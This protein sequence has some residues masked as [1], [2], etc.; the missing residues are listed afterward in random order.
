[1]GPLHKEYNLLPYL[2]SGV[3]YNDVIYFI[4]LLQSGFNYSCW[5]PVA[6]VCISAFHH[7]LDLRLWT[8]HL[9][10]KTDFRKGNN[11]LSG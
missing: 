2:Y 3:I 1:M 5:R 8:T 10:F 11:V 7:L 9:M 4:G 6:Q